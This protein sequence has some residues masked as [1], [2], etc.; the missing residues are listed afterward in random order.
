MGFCGGDDFLSWGLSIG[1][2]IF[3]GLEVG[4]TRVWRSGRIEC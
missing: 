4:E 1:D 3:E 2:S